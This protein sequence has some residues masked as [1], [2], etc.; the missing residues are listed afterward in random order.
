MAFQELA[1][2]AIT[3]IW[4]LGCAVSKVKYA[5]VLSKVAQSVY[6]LH[7]IHAYHAQPGIDVPLLMDLLFCVVEA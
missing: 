2:A 1:P 5:Q 6:T 4:D 3:Q 7:K